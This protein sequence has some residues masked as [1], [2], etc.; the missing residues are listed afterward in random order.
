MHSIDIL[1]VEYGTGWTNISGGTINASIGRVGTDVGTASILIKDATIDPSTNPNMKPGARVRVS[2]LDGAVWKRIYTGTIQDLRVTTDDGIHVN[3]TAVDNVATMSSLSAPVVQRDIADLALLLSG[4][5]PYTVDGA[6]VAPGASDPVG[7]IQNQT[8]WQ[9]VLLTT[10]SNSGHVFVDSDNVVNLQTSL[11]TTPVATLDTNVYQSIDKAYTTETVVNALT[12][13][14]L[15]AATPT[16]EGAWVD[17]GPFRDETSIS[18]WGERSGGYAVTGMDSSQV[19]T[20]AAALLA[21]TSQPHMTPASVSVPIREAAEVTRGL[22]ELYDYVT[23]VYPDG[24]S[25]NV[26]VDSISH[27]IKAN[28]WKVTYGFT[29]SPVT[30]NGFASGGAAVGP[31]TVT[32]E[33]LDPDVYDAFVNAQNAIT[34]IESTQEYAETKNTVYRQTSAPTGGTYSVNDIWFDTDDGNKPYVWNGTVW[35]DT[36]DADIATALANAT[37]AQTAANNA[38]STANTANTNATAAQTTASG[39]NKVTYS[40]SAPGTTANTAGDIWFV[41]N[42]TTGVITAQYEGLGGTSWAS[43]TVDN[44]VI[45]NL[46]AGK[47]T[48][49]TMS[50]DRIQAG[51]LTIGDISSLQTTLDAKETP[52]GAQAKANSAQT[53]AQSYTDTNYSNTKSLVGG[54]VYTGT[55]SI[56][57]GLIRTDTIQSGSIAADAINSKFT[58]TGPV[59]QTTATAN[60][61]IKIISTAN[62]GYGALYGYN[63]AGAQT[64]NLNGS[65]GSLT[66]VGDLNAGSTVNGAIITGGTLQ[67]TS[68]ANS[69][70]KISSTGMS[71]YNSGGTPTFTIS[72]ST[73]AVA[74]LGSLT[75]GSTIS[76]TTITGGVFQTAFS[77]ARVMIDAV[78]YAQGIKFYGSDTGANPGSV[79]G[80][81]GVSPKLTLASVTNSSYPQQG[82]IHLTSVTSGGLPILDATAVETKVYKITQSGAD[83]V[84][85]NKILCNDNVTTNYSTT[86]GGFYD[87]AFAGGGVTTAGINNLGR[88]IRAT[89]NTYTTSSIRFKEGVKTL[90]LDKAKSV[91]DMRS[92]SFYDTRE[93]DTRTRV[94]GFIAEEA[95]DLGTVDMWVGYDEDGKPAGIRYDKMS[96][97]HNVLINDL[98]KEVEHLKSE[99]NRLVN[100]E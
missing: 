37:A 55:T 25:I 83:S 35:T 12:V 94:P 88:I 34:A 60:R 73:G 43:R 78:G 14:R 3:I 90:S 98:Y 99:V 64:F 82:V 58:I 10:Q 22:L 30:A 91:L 27:D 32:S 80:Q 100:D 74:M 18:Q 96:A 11:P 50:G 69:G 53:A 31:G 39:K 15:D 38:Q 71:A 72:G 59:F 87:N 66:M 47:I 2:A 57:G 63:N 62:S 97:A 70:I 95:A 51:T 49:G 61:G 65:T 7:V 44:A 33:Q 76:G 56:N 67:T 5:M 52:T 45:A 26:F 86:V 77:G 89:N 6:V 36:Q 1:R 42:A 84:F 28:S 20:F 41:R 40:T 21:Q 46:D 75:S 17:E 85:N 29:A 9:S 92:V 48:F 81:G 93:E 8:L 54:W 68:T 13:Q 24:D 19:A 16:S 23:V 4:K 79:S